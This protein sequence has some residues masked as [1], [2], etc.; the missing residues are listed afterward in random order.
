MARRGEVW[1][2]SGEEWTGGPSVRGKYTQVRKG[3]ISLLCMP[4]L[5]PA[6]CIL[7]PASLEYLPTLLHALPVQPSY[8]ID[9]P[10]ISH[11]AK[12]ESMNKTEW[13]EE[14][15]DEPGAPSNG[16]RKVRQSWSDAQVRLG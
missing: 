8:F 7:H 1:S 6:F 4:H 14:E 12:Q 3:A 5:H 13:Q 9:C 16:E 11:H 15:E 10:P 2:D